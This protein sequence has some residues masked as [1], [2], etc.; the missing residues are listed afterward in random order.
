MVDKND[1]LLRELEEEMRREQYAKLWERY[2]YY[3]I[4][5]A[6]AVVALVGGVKAW[7]SYSLARAE[8][9]GAEYQAAVSLAASGKTE[10]A[11]KAFEAITSG[12]PG[13]YAALAALSEAGAYLKLDKRTEALAIFDRLADDRS[14]DP[15]LASYARLQAASLRLGEAD[16]TEM[17]NRLKPLTSDDSSWRYVARELLGTAALKAG[18]LDEAR[19]I[20]SPL[21]ADPGLSRGAA[22][23]IN[24]LMA[25]IATAEL[26]ASPAT[27]PAGDAE[28]PASAP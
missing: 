6:V 26:S 4:G 25:G 10:D 8:A 5:L 7:E 23:R 21:L 18:R 20:L 24:R 22:E 3:F 17:E 1:P 12:G 2:G 27:A 11:A 19:T 9:V 28:K 14:T 16:F 13:G 15:L